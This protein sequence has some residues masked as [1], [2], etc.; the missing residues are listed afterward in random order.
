MQ[1]VLGAVAGWIDPATAVSDRT[2]TQEARIVLL[3]IAIISGADGRQ[4]S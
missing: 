1:G 4:R 2:P 3:P